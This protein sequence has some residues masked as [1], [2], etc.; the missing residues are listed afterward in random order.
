MLPDLLDG[1]VMP[2]SL[3]PEAVKA[4]AGRVRAECHWHIAPW[5]TQ[6]WVMP[7]PADGIVDLD[8]LMLVSV[9][10]VTV[11]GDPLGPDDYD[12]SESGRLQLRSGIRGRGMRSLSITATHGHETC[13][14]DL[15]QLIAQLAAPGMGGQMVRSEGTGEFTTSYFGH[16][17]QS[18][19]APY[20]L[21]VVA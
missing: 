17:Q 15:V 11:D 16:A 10:S 13:P 8:T 3:D 9:E 20:T 7:V 6:T 21:P 2:A 18:V 19:T 4:A 5:H 12:W 14:P 1:Y